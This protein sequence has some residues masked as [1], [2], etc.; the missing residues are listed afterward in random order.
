[1]TAKTAAEWRNDAD[2]LLH[3]YLRTREAERGLSPFTQ[4][5]YTADIAGFFDYCERA[6]FAPLEVDRE[7]FRAYLTDLV[8]GGTAHD[9]IRRKTSTV[10]GFFRFLAREEV[11]TGDPLAG[12]RPPK[13]RQR[14]PGVLDIDAI[15]QL[16]ETPDLETLQGV[17]DRAILELLY[18]AGVRISELAGMTVA[19]VDFD[20]RT[21]R[22]TGKGNKERIALF[23]GPA[24]D[25]LRR[26]LVEARPLLTA[27]SR[28]PER[29]L[30]LNRFG[31]P[32][33][34]RAVQLSV[35]RYAIAAGIPES[36]HPHL[37]RHS[38]AT[39][40]LDNG[41]DLRV[42]QELLG[43]TSVNTT[44]IYLHVSVER[45]R[46]VYDRALRDGRRDRR[47]RMEKAATP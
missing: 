3:R 38:F 39:H 30:F 10:H 25:A 22:V 46:E 32:L 18:A 16:I 31:T 5:N 2:A 29:A 43:H 23:G 40:L 41:A 24:E 14:L 15:R 36:V 20:E 21:V 45:Q 6:G 47:S 28:R 17:R 9:S 8:D 7:R 35:R 37:L 11:T 1:M 42:V 44:Q 13:K 26:Y 34:Q 27:R 4:R 19:D 33:T 12:V